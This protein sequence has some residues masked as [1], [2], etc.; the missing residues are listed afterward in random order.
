MLLVVVCSVISVHFKMFSAGLT[1]NVVP[2]GLVYVGNVLPEVITLKR[3]EKPVAVFYSISTSLTSAL[4]AANVFP[5]WWQKC[6]VISSP[7][8]RRWIF[9]W[10]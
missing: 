5:Q 1:G 6:V 10:E 2:L 3:K 9:L 7:L 4:T 8:A